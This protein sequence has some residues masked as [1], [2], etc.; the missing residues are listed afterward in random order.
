MI[1]SFS[2]LIRLG[3]LLVTA[4][5]IAAQH[6]LVAEEG[7]V[8]NV[9]GGQ[10]MVLRNGKPVL[11]RSTGC[12]LEPAKEYFPV[13]VQ[14]D[15][16]EVNIHSARFYD[17]ASTFNHEFR[18]SAKF[19]SPYPLENVFL[20]VVLHP[21]N[22]EPILFLQEI[23][24]LKP[25]QTHPVTAN[26]PIGAPLGEGRYKLQLFAGGREIL[27]S[28]QSAEFRA[29]VLD[30]LIARKIASV[31][32]ANPKPFVGPSPEYPP[33]LRKQRLHG[34]VTVSMRITERGAVEN[35]VIERATDPAMGASVLAALQHWRFL[36]KVKEGRPVATKVSMPFGFTPPPEDGVK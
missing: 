8:V 27:H 33:T 22:Q 10:P 7:A 6:T 19:T 23:G 21:E 18:F 11:S 30:D 16:L 13:F 14:M 29:A 24:C 4:G 1:I 26:V 35:P 17:R 5:Q 12:T 34:E 25:Y 9:S 3:L 31:E 15:E 28:K 20:V 2:N 32:Q 36:P